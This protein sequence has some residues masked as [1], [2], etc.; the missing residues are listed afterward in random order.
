MGKFVDLTGRKFGKLTVIERAENKGTKTMWRCICDCGK[1]LETYASDLKKGHTKSC[2]CLT[3]KDLTGKRVGRLT[4]LEKT[5]KK[6]RDGC[7]LWKCVCDCGNYTYVPTVNLNKEDIKSCGCKRFDKEDLTGMRFSKLTVVEPVRINNHLKWRC[8]CDCGGETITYHY[9]LVKGRTKSCG[10]LVGEKA[11]ENF[12][13]H[14]KKRTR[15]Y[16]IWGG[17][18]NRCKD[19]DNKNYGGRGI[20]V[21]DEWKKFENFYNWAMENG[22]TDEL[23]ID[24]IDVNGNYCPENCRWA[25]IKTQANNTRNNIFI[26]YNG[27][28]KTVAEWAEYFNINPFTVYRR[29]SNN[30]D[31]IV[32]ITTPVKRKNST[33]EVCSSTELPKAD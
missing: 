24:R 11:M 18:I 2:G 32:A 7:F 33:K 6:Y 27:E 3:K 26:E 8:I 10:C 21:C 19:K 28:K 9:N 31:T 1:E 25:T 5:D 30:W 14:G 4:V 22:Y 29:I 17:M 15:I 13:T 12:T 23:T 16:G 20:I